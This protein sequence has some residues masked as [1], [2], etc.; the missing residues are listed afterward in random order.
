MYISQIMRINSKKAWL[1]VASICLVAILGLSAIYAVVSIN[2]HGRTYD[3]VK[4]I[5]SFEYGLLLG[6][7]PITPQ[8]D[9]NY[10]FD[11][12]IKAAAELYEAGKVEKIIASGG[13]YSGEQ[14]NGCNELE[15]M[16][17][18]LVAH[19]VPAR[20]IYL[21]YDGLRTINSIA[22]AK[23]KIDLNSCVIISQE[24]HNQR[25]LWLADHFGM[26]AVA[27]NAAPSHILQKRIKNIAREFLARPKMLLDLCFGEKPSFESQYTSYDFDIKNG[28]FK[29]GDLAFCGVDSAIMKYSADYYDDIQMRYNHTDSILKIL[30]ESKKES[31][32][33]I[34]GFYAGIDETNYLNWW[35][36]N[37]GM[38][39]R[40]AAHDVYLIEQEKSLIDSLIIAEQNF[41]RM[42]CG[43]G[44]VSRYHYLKYYN[45]KCMLYSDWNKQLQEL[46][47]NIDS[48][49]IKYVPIND[50]PM[51]HIANEFSRLHRNLT[52]YN[53]DNCKEYDKD[54]DR[55][56]LAA[57]Q[58]AW[59]NF[60]SYRNSISGR[61]RTESWN[62]IYDNA[63]HL[64]KRSFL[65]LL[66]NEFEGM[67][68]YGNDVAECLLSDDCS[69]EELLSYPGFSIKWKEYCSKFLNKQSRI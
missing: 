60:I 67:G 21:D 50:F 34:K 18:S 26:K 66:K 43:F 16:R 11:N 58:K 49:N 53:A 59:D 55:Q 45:I 4:D 68:F 63:T 51:S 35:L 7:S 57:L 22:K 10:Y 54:K 38:R 3:D 36:I 14:T 23:D 46:V 5:P 1:I 52:P 20:Y 37:H 31:S 29:N 64:F 40:A 12:R 56:A 30:C 41:A 13:D 44:D 69:D 6:T 15:A 28:E 42:H 33:I 17:D 61:L 25:A 65:I 32:D 48:E 47:F 8:G 24:Y 19:G 2:A 39:S 9:H 62:K 27:Y